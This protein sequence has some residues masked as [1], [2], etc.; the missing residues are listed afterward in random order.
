MSPTATIVLLWIAFAATHMG[1][2]SAGLR[3]RL[4]AVLGERPFQGAYSLIA[5]AIFI[6][7]VS[8]YFGNK[9]DGPWL[10]EAPETPALLW[11]LYVVNG[12]AFVLLVSSFVQPSPASMAGRAGAP[13]GVL[14][15]TRHPLFMAIALWATAHLVVN[16]TTAD[17]AFFGGM[18]AF[19]LAGAWHQDRRKLRVGP[20]EFREFHAAT[21]YWPFGGS[22][23]LEGL[24]TL[25]PVAVAIGVLLTL[26]IRHWHDSL[27]GG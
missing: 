10:W 5:L 3:P 17:V 16:S 13:R 9:H 6:P 27:F 20:P 1:L 14:L 21:P 4:T 8:V 22:R 12:V 23:T 26:A 11:P 25:P 18:L 2:A 24:R 7:L 15:L 19:S